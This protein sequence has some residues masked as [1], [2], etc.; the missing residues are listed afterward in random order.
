MS[1]WARQQSAQMMPMTARR[2]IHG[3][4]SFAAPGRIGMAMR[5]KP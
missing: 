1:V 5:M 4:H 2:P 3:A